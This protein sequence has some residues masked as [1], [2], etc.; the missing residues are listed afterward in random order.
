MYLHPPS[1]PTVYF[2]LMLK[3]TLFSFTNYTRENGTYFMHLMSSVCC[4]F[5]CWLGICQFWK[6]NA[7]NAGQYFFHFYH[8]VREQFILQVS[9][10]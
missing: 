5:L 4:K 1:Y 7:L 8:I 3:L 6:F 10:T 2:C 9:F